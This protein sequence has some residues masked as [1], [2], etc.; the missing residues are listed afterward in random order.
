MSMTAAGASQSDDARRRPRA[1]T[2]K[3]TAI[4][5]LEQI[6]LDMESGR[7]APAE[8]YRMAISNG[9]AAMTRMFDQVDF[10]LAQEFA[11]PSEKRDA[12]KE[13]LDNHRRAFVDRAGDAMKQEGDDDR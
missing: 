10:A 11:L 7:L 13:W 3:I 9:I 5:R 8:D 6:R 1:R 4:A 2:R 12:I